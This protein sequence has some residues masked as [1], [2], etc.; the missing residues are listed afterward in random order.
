M[1]SKINFGFEENI[2]LAEFVSKHPCLFDL[3]KFAYNKD[4]QTRE[5]AKKEIAKIVKKKSCK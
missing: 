5:N 2:L 1:I 4:Q 3:K